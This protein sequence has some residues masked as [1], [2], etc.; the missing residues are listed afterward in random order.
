MERKNAKNEANQ[1]KNETE[2]QARSIIIMTATLI[3]MI[4]IVR[5]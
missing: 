5:E 1:P 2:K 4:I 3:A